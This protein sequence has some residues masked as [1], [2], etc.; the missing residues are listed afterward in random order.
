MSAPAM[1]APAMSAPDKKQT[2]TS[3]AIVAA[4]LLVIFA[5]I[6]II[7][8]LVAPDASM[9]HIG[10]FSVVGLAGFILYFTQDDILSKA[11]SWM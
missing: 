1:S 4:A 3:G 11:L 8:M 2:I 9:S 10:I 5:I 7:A 6:H